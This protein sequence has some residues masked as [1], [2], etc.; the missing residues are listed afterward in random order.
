MAKKLLKTKP[1]LNK[2]TATTRSAP[3]KPTTSSGG[4]GFITDK[5]IDATKGKDNPKGDGK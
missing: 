1:K 3:V 5:I 2:T 4:G